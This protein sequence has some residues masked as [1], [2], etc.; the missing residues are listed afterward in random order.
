V[1]ILTLAEKLEDKTDPIKK[2]VEDVTI[3]L[4]VLKFQHIQMLGKKSIIL[5]G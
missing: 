3:T 2:N 5:D 1:R 4:R